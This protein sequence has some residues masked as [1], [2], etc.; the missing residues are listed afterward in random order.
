M[1]ILAAMD[2]NHVLKGPPS[3]YDMA[4]V[5]NRITLT[6]IHDSHGNG[7]GL[8]A[9]DFSASETEEK[10]SGFSS[11]EG[12]E[13][14]LAD[15]IDQLTLQADRDLDHTVSRV[16][17]SVSHVHHTVSRVDHSVSHVHHTVSRVDLS[18]SHVDHTMSHVHHTVSRVDHSVSHV[19]HTVSHVD[20]TPS[21]VDHTVSRVD[22]SVSRV[23][24]SVSRVDHSVSR[25]HH[26]V[27]HVDHT[28][29]H[30]DY[31]ESHVDHT[32]THA[33]RTVLEELGPGE[34]RSRSRG[35]QEEGVPSKRAPRPPTSTAVPP[36]PHAAFLSSPLAPPARKTEGGRPQIARQQRLHALGA[37]RGQG[38]FVTNQSPSQTV[39]VATLGA[40][41][42]LPAGGI[43]QQFSVLP[44]CESSTSTHL[45][46]QRPST[47]PSMQ[48]PSTTHPSMQC[49]GGRSHPVDQSA[50]L[51]GWPASPCP[52]SQGPH[53][54]AMTPMTPGPW[55]GAPGGDLPG[56]V[57]PDGASALQEK[58]RQIA[59]IVQDL[60]AT[61]P[62]GEP[63]PS[64][65]GSSIHTVPSPTGSFIHTVPSPTGSFIHT[66]PSPT[67]SFI[68]TEP[69]P[70]RSFIHTVPSPAGPSAG[71][72]GPTSP[73]FPVS[74]SPQ[75][76]S[77]PPPY[78]PLHPSA[79]RN[80][81]Q[82]LGSP[83]PPSP[84][85]KCTGPPPLQPPGTPESRQAVDGA[86]TVRRTS[87][88][89]GGGRAQP[90]TARE[91]GG[92][93]QTAGPPRTMSE[94]LAL[95]SDALKDGSLTVSPHTGASATVAAP[96]RASASQGSWGQDCHPGRAPASSLTQSVRSSPG[97]TTHTCVSGHA[98]SGAL[99]TC[100]DLSPPSTLC[101]DPSPP[102][103]LPS[104]P[105][106]SASADSLRGNSPAAAVAMM[107]TSEPDSPL[108]HASAG[109][110]PS[111]LLL[112]LPAAD[113][114]PG[115]FL[116]PTPE[117]DCSSVKGD[118][119]SPRGRSSAHDPSLTALTSLTTLTSHQPFPLGAGG[120]PTPPHAPFHDHPALHT[121]SP[122]SQGG[123]GWRGEEE[124]EDVDYEE[125]VVEEVLEMV[126]DEHGVWKSN[127]DGDKFLHSL[128]VM[129]R[130]AV[131]VDYLHCLRH[132]P[133]FTHALNSFN[134]TLE[135]PVYS[136]VCL[137][138]L[139]LTASMIQLG[140]DV[141]ILCRYG[142]QAHTPLHC[143]VE[144][145]EV[146]M[147]DILLRSEVIDLNVRRGS[148]QCTALMVA[149][150]R[151]VCGE[152]GDH[153]LSII[154]RLMDHDNEDTLD[155]QARD[156]RSGKTALMM[157]VETKDVRVVDALLN[158][159][160]LDRARHLINMR[161][162]AGNS[163]VHLAAGLLDVSPD[164]K[165]HM[166]RRLI[167]MGGDTALRNNEGDT[168]R[169]WAQHMIDRVARLSSGPSARH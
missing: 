142:D 73:P 15:H 123:G 34:K 24:H 152:G 112:L 139:A 158:D 156:P 166:L 149:V 147:V 118:A 169:H 70:T 91:G 151:Q 67:G 150:T 3:S 120:L 48:R 130:E 106:S 72:P 21:H 104:S 93:V 119:Q 40:G 157:G 42:G 89:Q 155:L 78:P 7:L 22:H 92:G 61:C 10:D 168:P 108:P 50:W 77:P 144:R 53:V 164:V 57:L 11:E 51:K 122:S 1:S 87:T 95:L 88:P 8:V 86:Q 97:H 121:L 138:K 79:T 35:L 102:R 29:S 38:S 80:L 28:V 132:R 117:S 4:E 5:T 37:G 2:Q 110:F 76:T 63:A 36:P 101:R 84:P 59:Q 12:P 105:S 125:G 45:S 128:S 116:P 81:P 129:R 58:E 54:L 103:P 55:S 90:Q 82:A 137:G 161:N 23:D 56:D 143:A 133:G 41:Q 126:C 26:T 66:E 43:T 31:T 153:R 32:V 111:P 75:L 154:T 20:H 64:P 25:V 39:S 145:G 33:N 141:N 127:S 44:W 99:V 68:H 18:V 162:R 13:Y 46:M 148:D 14:D 74:P 134:N 27:S 69:S 165:L 16:D 146:S 109:T 49:V 100:H 131:A 113:V 71:S 47:H 136:A 140:A 115:V 135:T 19:H 30:V 17:H 94:L 62:Q 60:M 114:P 85:D 107:T 65:T 167:S 9:G 96:N 163:A 6:H 160:D 52:L 124:E 98:T 83:L 159:L